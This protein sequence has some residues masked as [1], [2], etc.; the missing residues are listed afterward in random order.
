MKICYV[1]H[2]Y[3]P[4]PGGTEYYVKNMAEETKR[5]GHD[6]TVLAGAHQG[7]QNGIRVVGNPNILVEEDF[8]LVVV[9]G[10]G[11]PMQ[12]LVLRHAKG[13][14]APV[15]FMIIR[16]E[17]APQIFPAMENADFIACSTPTDWEFVR[18]YKNEHKAF[19]V[20]HS[21]SPEDVRPGFSPVSKPYIVSVGGFW[22]HKGHKQLSEGWTVNNHLVMTGYN[23]DPNWTPDV[24][25]KT[26]QEVLFLENKEDVLRYIASAELLVLNSEYEGFGLVL[27][28]AM[29]NNTPWAAT[30]VAGAE[31][32]QD[33]GFVYDTL[34][35]LMEYIQAGDYIQG[36]KSYVEQNHLVNVTVQQLLSVLT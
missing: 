28:E 30:R 27:L 2:R 23:N 21:I 16:P 19:Q 10:S 34:D 15:V 12:D 36:D 31:V 8:D 20:N 25:D 3:Y 35:Q 9:H 26:N 6:V 18:K 4:Y 17:E 11:V 29:M 33:H 7:D 5:Q 24:S 1:A 14:K 32:L 13:I 22:S